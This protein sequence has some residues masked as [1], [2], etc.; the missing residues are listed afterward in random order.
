MRWR[1]ASGFTLSMA[2]AGLLIGGSVGSSGAQTG[3]SL[4]PTPP[5]PTPPSLSR[6]Q[7]LSALAQLDAVVL[8]AMQR[9]GVPGV[10]VAVV[11]RDEV[12]YAKGFGVREVGKPEPIDTDTVFQLASVSKPI[13]ST[14]VAGVVG[15][16]EIAWDDPVI[17]H[18]PSFMLSDPY[19][20]AHATFTDLMSHRSGLYTGAGDFLEDLGYG[21]PYIHAHLRLQPLDSF[22]SSYHYSNFGYTSGGEAAAVAAGTTWEE[23]ADE[24]LFKPLGMTRSSYRHKD[25]AAKENRARLHVRRMGTTAPAWVAKF[26]RQ[27]DAE[28]PAGGASASINDIARFMRLQINGGTFEGKAIIDPDALTTTHV[29][30]VIPGPPRTPASRTSFYGLGWNVA[31]DDLGRA[32][33]SHSGAFDLGA[34]TNVT[35]LLGEG[36]GIAVLTNGEPVGVPEAIANSFLDIAQHGSQTVDWFGFYGKVFQ[37]MRDAQG[38]A[39]DYANPPGDAKRPG[40]LAD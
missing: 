32:V 33:L 39:F 34:S 8:G 40:P 14:I 1:V 31:Y 18:D 4:R 11:Y 23:L 9:T 7:V 27:P 2:L 15:R 28:A 35:I 5:N 26:D 10:A 30:Q 38:A 36:L 22:R 3:N 24:I 6:E 29:P 37:A 13:A 21:W 20:S 16:G 19:V 17:K 25:Y 12:V